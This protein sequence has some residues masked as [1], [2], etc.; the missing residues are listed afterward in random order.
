MPASRVDP[1]RSTWRMN[2]AFLLILPVLCGFPFFARPMMAS[3]PMVTVPA[4]HTVLLLLP[5]L[6]LA[7]GGVV[8]TC[9]VVGFFTGQWL[10]APQTVIVKPGRLRRGQEVY[11][12]DDS[13]LWIDASTPSSLPDCWTRCSRSRSMAPSR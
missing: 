13:R 7:V 6:A 12:R 2:V 10:I 8:Y 3:A 11:R 1:T 5:F 9:L 4:L